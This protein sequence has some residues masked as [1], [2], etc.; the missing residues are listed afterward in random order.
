LDWAHGR[1]RFLALSPG[2]KGQPLT[3]FHREA[4]IMVRLQIQETATGWH[5]HLH[6]HDRLKLD[7]NYTF[8]NKRDALQR[9]KE[10]IEQ[11]LME[12]EDC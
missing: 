9:G 12:V 5:V 10:L 4:F 11:W 1:S 8:D 7:K 3:H 2:V 6:P